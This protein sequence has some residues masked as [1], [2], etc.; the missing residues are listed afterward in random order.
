MAK[1]FYAPVIVTS[2]ENKVGELEIWV[3][4]DLHQDQDITVKMQVLDF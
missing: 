4:N 3:V 1:R 2:F